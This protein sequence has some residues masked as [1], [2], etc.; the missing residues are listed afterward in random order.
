MI[1][2]QK[3]RSDIYCMFFF[4][5]LS[6]AIVAMIARDLVGIVTDLWYGFGNVMM[7][8]FSVIEQLPI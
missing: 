8:F 1:N 4:G 6:C 3:N 5:L 2:E 7:E